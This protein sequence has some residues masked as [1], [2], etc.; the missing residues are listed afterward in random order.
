[1]IL[2]NTGIA[3]NIKRSRGVLQ[4][5][6]RA[7]NSFGGYQLEAL[8]DN[9]LLVFNYYFTVVDKVTKYFFQVTHYSNQATLLANGSW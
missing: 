2:L 8:F 4:N 9:P 7:E 1:M 6:R 3:S 5:S